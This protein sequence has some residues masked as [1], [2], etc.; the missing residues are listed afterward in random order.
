VRNFALVCFCLLFPSI[1]NAQSKNDSWDA[2]RSLRVG[3]KVEVVEISMKK[4]IGTFST[5]TDEA[6]QLRQG[7]NDVGIRKESV[8]RV[9]LLEKSHRL[10]NVLIFAAIG[11]GAGAGIGAAAA[12][13]HSFLGRG[14]ATAVGAVIGLASGAGIGAAI[15]SH[16][17]VYRV[18]SAKS[19]EPKS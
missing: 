5:V 9:T 19:K 14:P 17:T 8:V 16:P 10:R 3:E 12:G 4:Q 13:S 15:P 11:G 6:I 1:L 2:L 7:S 18:E